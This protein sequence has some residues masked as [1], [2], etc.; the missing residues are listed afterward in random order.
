MVL[1]LYITLELRLKY[2]FWSAQSAKSASLVGKRMK[3]EREINKYWTAHTIHGNLGD[4]RVGR[5]SY[6]RSQALWGERL[7][8]ESRSKRLDQRPTVRITMCDERTLAFEREIRED[9]GKGTHY[10]LPSRSICPPV[11]NIAKSIFC[12]SVIG[13]CK[14]CKCETM[15]YWSFV[16]QQGCI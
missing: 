13:H 6:V 10:T 4:K 8:I 14:V 11:G 3:R 16:E 15:L 1:R 12:L 9:Y 2:N 5:D 7:R